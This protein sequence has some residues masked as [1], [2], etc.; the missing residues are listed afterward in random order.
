[1]VAANTQ[2]KVTATQPVMMVKGTNTPVQVSSADYFID[3]DGVLRVRAPVSAA[4]SGGGTAPAP[5]ASGRRRLLQSASSTDEATGASALGGGVARV[6]SADFAVSNGLFMVPTP[7]VVSSLDALMSATNASAARKLL[8]TSSTTTTEPATMFTPVCDWISYDLFNPSTCK[9][10]GLYNCVTMVNT[11]SQFRYA[12]KLAI[13]M[14][15]QGNNGQGQYATP[16]FWVKPC[17]S[18]RAPRDDDS[19][20]GP[21]H[22]CARAGRL[23]RSR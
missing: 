1:M 2:T 21:T 14:L 8:Q 12:K 15:S 18:R 6:S 4:T 3:S 7:A 22:T 5:A 17:V 10:G 19:G 11:C 13:Y 9:S 23:C 20:G 16:G